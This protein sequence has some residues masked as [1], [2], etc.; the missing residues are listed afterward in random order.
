M[1]RQTGVPHHLVIAGR[2]G[3]LYEDVYERVRAEGITEAV[4]FLGF[5][6]DHD[7]PALYTLSDLMV[8]PSLYEGFGL[9][10]L[11][12]MACGTPVV[13]SNNSS[14]PESAGSAALMVN[15]AETEEISDAMA[16]VLAD[17]GLQARMVELGHI[18]AAQFT[19]H[20]AAQRLLAA[21]KQALA[22]G[23]TKP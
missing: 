10:P 9:P 14:M 18:Q 4:H 5:V 16:R 1:R 13:S 20:A 15:A 2:P 22:E 19:W 8:F 21:Y 23:V 11:E 3:W 6:P 17:T 7:L 12:A